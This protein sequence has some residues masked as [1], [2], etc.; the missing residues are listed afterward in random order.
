M[1]Q[2]NHLKQHNNIKRHNDVIQHN[3]VKQHNNV[4]QQRQTATHLDPQCHLQK[5]PQLCKAVVK[6]GGHVQ[7]GCFV[8]GA[9][10]TL[11]CPVLWR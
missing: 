4:E 1:E 8:A 6:V 2:H 5:V 7:Q 3:D 10:W 9:L 11:Q